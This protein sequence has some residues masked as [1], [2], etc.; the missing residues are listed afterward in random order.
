MND[1]TQKNEPASGDLDV[2]FGNEG[3]VEISD[4]D[5]NDPVSVYAMS[6][7]AEGRILGCGITL[8]WG[9]ALGDVHVFR[10]EKDGALD[11]TFGSHGF[12]LLPFNP[13]PVFEKT[14]LPFD[15]LSANDASLIVLGQLQ[16]IINGMPY[17]VPAACRVMADGTLDESFGEAGLAIYR[18]PI[19][20][21]MNEQGVPMR[22]TSGGI[23]KSG[24]ALR[25]ADNSVLVA[26]GIYDTFGNYVTSYLLRIQKSG[27]LDPSFGTS[28]FVEM[29][30]SPAGSWYSIDV[31]RQG[32]I[33]VAGDIAWKSM[34]ARFDAN[35]N[36]D[37]SFGTDGWAEIENDANSS[38]CRDVVALDNGKLLTV[39]TL[40]EDG[41]PPNPVLQKTGVLR[42]TVDGRPDPEFNDGEMVVFYRKANG[43]IANRLIRDV[44][45]RAL[46]V[47]SVVH[48]DFES[49]P[50]PTIWNELGIIRIYPTGIVDS[51]FGDAGM[52]E[53]SQ[54]S[55]AEGVGIQDGVNLVF[56][57]Q[58]LIDGTRVKIGRIVG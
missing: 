11:A 33:V 5:T 53:F 27:Q 54:F 34:V 38:V 19:P 20:S 10:L 8:H 31:D 37:K 28:G 21:T 14:L 42:L 58:S 44:G 52:A 2:T 48:F 4:P 46:I 16:A 56:A 6:L 51:S 40:Y 1:V 9:R 25:Q 13:E 22:F 23:G 47:V 49:V 41:I 26:S 3:V 12:C 36:P 39:T 17:T 7:D 45:D 55:V 30:N 32:N 35:G 24:K 29:Q 57:A 50:Y 15:I 43:Y 18:V